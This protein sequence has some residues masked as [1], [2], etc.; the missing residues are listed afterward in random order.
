MA[1]L[2]I[3]NISLNILTLSFPAEIEREYK[4]D[5]FNKSLKHVRVAMLI[6]IAFFAVFGILDSW[7]VP[8]A[9]ELLWFI[10][11]AIYCPSVLFLYLFSFSKHFKPYMQ[12]CIALSVLLAGLSIPRI[13]EYCISEVCVIRA[14]RSVRVSPC[15]C[16]C[17]CG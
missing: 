12:L 7:L 15:G 1:I 3:D 6:A 5:F 17:G 10:R 13:V 2:S 4:E 8:D 9:K 11:Y 14:L 16:L